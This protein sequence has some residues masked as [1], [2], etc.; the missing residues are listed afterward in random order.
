MMNVEGLVPRS[1]VDLA[2]SGHHQALTY[3]LSCFL[4]PKGF[5]VYVSDLAPGRIQVCVL[6]RQVPVRDRLVRF[7]CYHLWL[8]DAAA[9]QQVQ[10]VAQLADDTTPLWQEQVR[11]AGVAETLPVTMTSPPLASLPPA[12]SRSPFRW[13]RLLLFNQFAALALVVA[14]CGVVVVTRTMPDSPEPPPAAAAVV[15]PFSMSLNPAPDQPKLYPAIAPLHTAIAQLPRDFSIPSAYQ[16]QIIH[17]VAW[18]HPQ[19]M[20]ALTFDDGPWGES[21]AQILNILNQ[22]QVPATFFWVGQHLQ[23]FPEL[24]QQ[25]AAAGHAIGNHSWSHPTRPMSPATAAQ[26]YERTQQLIQALTGHAPHLFRPPG[27]ALHTGL[28]AYAQ[29][30]GA[31]VMMWSAD[32]QDYMLSAPRLTHNVLSQ[33]QPGGIIL[34]HDGGGDRTPTVQ[35][36]PKIIATLRQQGYEFVTVPELL[37]RSLDSPAPLQPTSPRPA[38]F[39][40][41][42]VTVTPRPG[43]NLP[44]VTLTRPDR[45][46]ENLPRL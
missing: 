5:R 4:V 1:L 14:Y 20:V 24:A 39:L 7:I 42:E 26:E 27:G 11:L 43:L 38:V 45:R 36:L 22:Y 33:T 19:K 13:L 18:P 37:Q 6:C 30:R 29:Q 41:R 25:I 28:S 3:W 2:K 17:R 16:G 35:S 10:I 46:L 40:Q 31:A 23:R 44:E 15:T 12:S 34:L 8:L 21:T 32:S 9:I